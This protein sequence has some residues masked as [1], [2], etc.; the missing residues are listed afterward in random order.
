M[1]RTKIR[2]SIVEDL[3]ITAQ[4]LA[5]DSVIT[6]K[7]KDHNVT[8]E[9]LAEGLCERLLKSEKV[10]VGVQLETDYLADTDFTIP[11]SLEYSLDDFEFRVLVYRNGQ[12]L[13]NG[14]GP[15][16]DEWS[17]IEVY[18]GSDTKKLRFGMNI[19]KGETI[20]VVIL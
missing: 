17:P 8:C 2:G 20:Q 10:R 3:T 1:P 14:L 11:E 6:E 7:I 9:K 15:P 12:L 18:P 4:D 13:F 16:P 19:G 5:T